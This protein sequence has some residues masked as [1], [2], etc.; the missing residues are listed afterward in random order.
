M[1]QLKNALFFTVLM[2]CLKTQ[3]QSFAWQELP[4]PK[5]WVLC[6]ES[7]DDHLFAGYSGLGVFRSKNA[8]MTWDT[9]NVGLQDWVVYD[10]LATS[11]QELY[12]AT[13]TQGVFYSSNG[14]ESWSPFNQG[15]NAAYTYC[16]LKKGE[17]LFAG[18]TLGVY[19]ASTKDGKWSRL[20]LPKSL[21]PNQIVQCLH[22]AGNTIFAGSSKGVYYSEDD[23]KNWNEIPNITP[24]VVTTMVEYKGK[25][26]IGTSGNGIV[27]MDLQTKA[28]KKSSEFLGTLDTANSITSM[29]V[30]SNGVLL[31]GNNRLGIFQADSTLN[32]GLTTLDVRALH[33]HKNILYTGTLQRGILAFKQKDPATAILE[34]PK[35][36]ALE[37]EINPNPAVQFAKIK[38][39]VKETQVLNCSLFSVDGCLVKTIS[40][41]QT[42]APGEYAIE[43]N[44]QNLARGIYYCRIADQTGRIGAIRRLIVVN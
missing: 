41:N 40:H 29:L 13:L 14:G 32:R 11:S 31:K 18:T 20:V 28:F 25:L 17:Q 3:A 26:L 12:A 6:M 19:T 43:V 2:F 34:T 27:E 24:Y 33:E 35:S 42:F 22:L 1:I 30:T 15:I 39:L 38:L 44:V 9:M 10:L 7:V 8:G 37:L 36:T 16:L 5:G 21:A 4:C 23:G